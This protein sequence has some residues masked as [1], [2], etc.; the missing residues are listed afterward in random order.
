MAGTDHQGEEVPTITKE[1]QEEFQARVMNELEEAAQAMVDD[2]F[3]GVDPM[4]KLVD[5]VVVENVNVLSDYSFEFVQRFLQR[6]YGRKFHNASQKAMLVRKCK[7][8]DKDDSERKKTI[9]RLQTLDMDLARKLE[10]E[11]GVQVLLF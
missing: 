5:A 1:K 4:Q 8:E 10:R 6:N 11:T 9:S 2:P 7:H 3:E